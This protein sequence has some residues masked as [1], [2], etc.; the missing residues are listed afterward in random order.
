[1]SKLMRIVSLVL[2]GL[3]VLLTSEWCNP[4]PITDPK[5]FAP[6]PT[7]PSTQW[8]LTAIVVLFAIGMVVVV[9]TLRSE[10]RATVAAR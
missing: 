5:R 10:P 4:N 9:R 6:Q 3:G 7:S 8:I 1:M 2:V